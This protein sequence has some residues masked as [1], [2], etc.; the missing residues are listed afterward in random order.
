MEEKKTY[1][2]KLRGVLTVLNDEQDCEFRAQRSTGQSS[3]EE[4]AHTRSSKLYR[5][6]G[7]KKPKVIAHLSTLSASADPTAD[8]Y[9]ELDLLTKG[10]K[11]KK[12]AQ[13]LR[14]RRLLEE[15]GV[16]VTLNATKR[17]L[18][19]VLSID[20]A[21]QSDYQSELIKRMQKISQCLVINQHSLV[22][23]RS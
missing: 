16:S 12:K 20:L 17:K 3:Q 15:P 9:D 4:I 1:P 10:L 14:G 11:D 13:P 23:L 6:M 21:K 7:E 8:L 5:T 18:E 22:K 19:C 2:L